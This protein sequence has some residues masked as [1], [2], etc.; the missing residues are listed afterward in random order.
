MTTLKKRRSVSK[1]LAMKVERH[2]WII[3]TSMMIVRKWSGQSPSFP[4][5]HTHAL[6]SSTIERGAGSGLR[7]RCSHTSSTIASACVLWAIIRMKM[8]FASSDPLLKVILSS[9]QEEKRGE[10]N[11]IASF[12][13]SDYQFHF[14]CCLSLSLSRVSKVWYTL[15]L[16]AVVAAAVEQ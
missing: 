6:K 16:T 8:Q 4:L 11:R 13:S 5:S 3:I 12:L 1:L 9:S 2:T 15:S 14:E 10:I 7:G